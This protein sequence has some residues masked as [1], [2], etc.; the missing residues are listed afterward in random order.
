MRKTIALSLA[1]VATSAVWNTAPSLAQVIPITG[2]TYTLNGSRN[3]AGGYD[4]TITPSNVL[5][6]AG[7]IS[8]T[9]I[10]NYSYSGTRAAGAFSI[11]A[12]T[13]NN[14]AFGNFPTSG[15]NL[16]LTGDASGSVGGNA[17]TAKPIV[18]NGAIAIPSF[19]ASTGGGVIS[20]FGFAHNIIGGSL[21]L[22]VPVVPAPVIPAP[23]IPAP[24][25]PAPVTCTGCLIVRPDLLISNSTLTDSAL[26]EPE[27]RQEY[28]EDFS[29]SSFRGG[30]VLGLEDK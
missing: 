11:S 28:K 7:V 9:A 20:S 29:T 13:S 4:V 23:V 3:V 8:L 21:T 19:Q 25:I 2:G 1:L 26:Q 14:F 27:Y 6:P 30:R 24:M 10:T 18:I 5:S 15:T 16:A 17:F 22:S 12:T